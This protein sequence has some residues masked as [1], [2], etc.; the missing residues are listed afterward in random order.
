VRHRQQ[1]FTC[2]ISVVIHVRRIFYEAGGEIV[3]DKEM[4]RRVEV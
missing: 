3:K 4:E 1:D 2:C